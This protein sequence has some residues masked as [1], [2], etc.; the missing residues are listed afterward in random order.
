MAI[1]D[2]PVPRPD[3]R[4]LVIDALRGFDMFWIIGEWH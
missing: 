4:L 3:E 1:D 2:T